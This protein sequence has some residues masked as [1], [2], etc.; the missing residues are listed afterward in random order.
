MT[1]IILDHDSEQEWLEQRRRYITASE[2]SRLA[3]SSSAWDEIRAEKRGEKKFAGNAFTR[4]GHEREPRIIEKLNESFTDTPVEANDK[5]WVLEGTRWAATPDAVGEACVVDAKTGSRDAFEEA[6][7]KYTDQVIWQMLV[8]GKSFGWL[9]FEERI[10]DG[11]FGQFLP[12]EVEAHY[13]QYDETRAEELMRIAN[14]FLEGTDMD[15]SIIMS[16]Y[17]EAKAQ[18]DKAQT[19][20]NECADAIKA[21]ADG[22]KFTYADDLG[23]VTATPAKVG[24]R[25]DSKAFKDAHPD[26]FAEFQ[27]PSTTA[28]RVTFTEK[29]GG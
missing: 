22:G 5:L 10:D 9:V 6:F 11:D 23:S 3:H 7:D 2:V 16:D 21:K 15:V 1:A 28:A 17:F 26:L 29:K 27:C 14:R 8:C 25:F 24:T 19:L 20:M 12:G 13:I 4:W 18:R